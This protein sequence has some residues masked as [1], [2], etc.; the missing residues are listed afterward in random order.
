MLLNSLLKIAADKEMKKKASKTTLD[1]QT[2]KFNQYK[3]RKMA[4]IQDL[5]HEYD[6]KAS[7]QSDWLAQCIAEKD[8]EM[9]E[10]Q[11]KHEAE[12]SNGCFVSR[13]GVC[14]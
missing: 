6:T 13:C 3:T 9:Q 5:R 14:S 2:K 7:K 12:V 4:E 1:E 8:A 11:R 10:M